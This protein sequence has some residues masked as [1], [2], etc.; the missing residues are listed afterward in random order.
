MWLQQVLGS[1]KHMDPTRSCWHDPEVD[2]IYNPLP[3]NMHLEWSVKAMEAG[4]HVL[5]EKPLGLTIQEVEEMIR[6]RDEQ[7]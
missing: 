7:G 3:N 1:E 4:K 6:V 5:C 2:A